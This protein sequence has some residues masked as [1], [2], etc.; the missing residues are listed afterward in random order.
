MPLILGRDWQDHVFPPNEPAH[1]KVR[2]YDPGDEILQ[3][4]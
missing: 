1:E 3:A 4:I 2:F